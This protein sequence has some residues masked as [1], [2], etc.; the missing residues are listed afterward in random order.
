MAVQESSASVDDHV[1]EESCGPLLI[2]KLEEGLHWSPFSDSLHLEVR[3]HLI[4]LYKKGV[5]YL[6]NVRTSKG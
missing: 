5:A 2:Q 4:V 1:D 3:G 6:K